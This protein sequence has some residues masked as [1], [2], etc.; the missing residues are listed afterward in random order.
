[1]V[2]PLL[3]VYYNRPLHSIEIFFLFHIYSNGFLPDMFGGTFS[4]FILFW[5]LPLSNGDAGAFSHMGN[6]IKFI[7]ESLRTT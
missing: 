1:M 3:R 4:S 5:L 6:D 2:A 7:D